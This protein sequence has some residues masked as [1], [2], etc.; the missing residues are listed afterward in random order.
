[1]VWSELIALIVPPACVACRAPLARASSRLCAARTRRVAVRR[2]QRARVRDAPLAAAA[3]GQRP[4]AASSVAPAGGRRRPALAA[5][6]GARWSIADGVARSPLAALEVPAGAPRGR[7]GAG[8]ARG[9]EP[10]G[11]DRARRACSSRCRARRPARRRRPRGF[12]PCARSSRRAGGHVRRHQRCLVQRAAHLSRPARRL[13]GVRE[14]RPGR[15]RSA[16]R[17]AGQPP[18]CA[19]EP[20]VHTTGATLDACARALRAGRLRGGGRDHHARGRDDAASSSARARD[21]TPASLP[22]DL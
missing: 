13:A 7:A 20:D 3:R 4:R 6:G 16:P 12:D 19:C 2:R 1:M 18:R 5:G 17:A 9:G 21:G 10:A 22:R 15:G 14:R 11:R 8:G